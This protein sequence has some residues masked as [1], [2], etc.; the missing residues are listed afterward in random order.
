MTAVWTLEVVAPPMSSGMVKPSRV[1]SRATEV[2]SSRVPVNKKAKVGK[3][4]EWL[5]EQGAIVENTVPLDAELVFNN[6]VQKKSADF[7]L[8][9]MGIK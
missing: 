7:F 9:A 8:K 6:A 3:L 2:I 5:V 4:G 1:N